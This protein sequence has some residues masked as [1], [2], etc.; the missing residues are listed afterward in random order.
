MI[1]SELHRFID[2]EVKGLYPQW[3]PT[4]A[5]LRAWMSHLGSLDWGRARAAVQACFSEQGTNYRRPVL[6]RFLEYARSLSRRQKG[7]EVPSDDLTTNVFVEC[8]IPPPDRPH[9]A[10]ARKGVYVAPRSKQ[11]DAEYVQACVEPMRVRFGQL[12]GGHWITLVAHPRADDGLLGD[13][14]RQRAC[15]SILAGDDTP[16]RRFLQDLLSRKTSSPA[17]RCAQCLTRK[18]PEGEPTPIGR[19]CEAQALVPA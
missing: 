18:P 4:D 1:Q 13:P 5:E 17:G 9:L 11:S 12:P 6:G 10:G 15:E 3:E 8:F 14:A 16:G 19:L 2:E 7:A